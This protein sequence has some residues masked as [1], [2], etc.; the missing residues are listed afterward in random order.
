MR[1]EDQTLPFPAG[2]YGTDKNGTAI[3]VPNYVEHT[4]QVSGTWTGT[5]KIQG[6][7]NGLDFSDLLTFT[8]NGVQRFA[9]IVKHIRVVAV[10]GFVNTDAAVVWG[11][12]N[13][14]SI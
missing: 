12:F 9:H 5:V 1:F 6:S 10:S 8:S 14:R 2:P 3:F 11:A 13:S 4:V 7:M